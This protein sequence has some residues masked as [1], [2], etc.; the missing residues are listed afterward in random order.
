MILQKIWDMDPGYFRL[1]HA[2]KTVLAIVVTL[3]LVHGEP[4][5]F[6]LMA[7]IVSGFSMQGAVAKSFF[8]RMI[9]IITLNM[10]YF[11]AF[12]IGL[13]ARDFVN[14]T[15][16]V[17]VCAGFVANYVRRFGLKNSVAPM[18]G[19]SLCFF[20]TMLPFTSTSQAWSHLYG[21]VIALVVSVL[22]NGLVFPENYPRLFVANSNRLFDVLARGM[23]ELRRY[24]LDTD[25]VVAFDTVPF[26]RITDTLTRLLE[27]NQAMDESE[28]FIDQDNKIND[29]LLQQYA[30]MNAYMMMIDAYGILS[31]HHHQLSRPA[32]LEISLFYKQF[33][34]LLASMRMRTDYTVSFK[35]SLVSVARTLTPTQPSEP[36][37]I[38]VLLNLKL[39]FNLF[40]RHIAQLI[41]GSNET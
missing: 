30:L 21:V 20:A 34:T 36:A 41:R 17:L 13:V 14:G 8:S 18:M 2:A 25:E 15:M 11:L 16:I 4:Q 27:S 33:E 38:I 3:L 28:V 1:K 24:I 19:W 23:H 5:S 26:M 37:I 10:A 9:Q 6:K 31:R 7:G 22:V 35:G 12:T 29:I 39:S 32:R 40:N